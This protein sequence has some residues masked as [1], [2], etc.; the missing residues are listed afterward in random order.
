MNIEIFFEE[1][2]T[3]LD[4]AAVGLPCD[5]LVPKVVAVVVFFPTKLQLA[6]AT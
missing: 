5:Q 2:V 6:K 1:I 4:I 3:K